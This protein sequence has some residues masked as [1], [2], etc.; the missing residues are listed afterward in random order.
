MT[1]L[2]KRLAR[3]RRRLL[4]APRVRTVGCDCHQANRYF[5]LGAELAMVRLNS[6]HMLYVDPLDEHV[7]ANII[8]HGHWETHVHH[9]V[10]ALIRPGFRIIEVGANI[11]YYTLTMA[12]AVGAE[13]FVTAFEGNP[14][15]AGLVQRSV[16]LNGYASRVH[17][18]PKAALDQQGHIDFVVSRRNSGGGYV[19]I[20]EQ[21]PYDDGETLKV[22]AVRIDDQDVERVDLIRIDAEGSEPFILRGAEAVLKTNPDI[23]LCLEWSVIQMGSRTSVPDFV[24]WLDGLGFRFWKIDFDSRLIPMSLDDMIVSPAADVIAARKLPFASGTRA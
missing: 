1:T 9:A 15:M 3:M 7:S 20:W 6:G 12:D 23:I 11:G 21:N 14:R 16:L 19:S 4:G 10:L 18:V 5:Y 2:R 24:N 17:I 13:G 8:A 22:E